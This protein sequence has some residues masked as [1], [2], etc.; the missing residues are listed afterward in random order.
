MKTCKAL[1]IALLLMLLT[2]SS[3]LAEFDAVPES[4][5]HFTKPD[6]LKADVSTSDGLLRI[7]VNTE[8]TDWEALLNTS[9][10]GDMKSII[11]PL[12]VIK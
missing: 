7:A 12:Q 2:I 1:P 5:I 4:R 11:L 10:D 6:G 9:Y 8:D 3:A